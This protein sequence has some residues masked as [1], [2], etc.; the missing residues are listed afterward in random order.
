MDGQRRALLDVKM[1]HGWRFV[2][3]IDTYLIGLLMD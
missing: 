3:L 1:E 2:F